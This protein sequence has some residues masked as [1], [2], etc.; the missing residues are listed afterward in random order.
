MGEKQMDLE[1][2]LVMELV[3]FGDRFD[4][5]FEGVRGY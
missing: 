5:Q 1:Y 3:E 4:M 2:I